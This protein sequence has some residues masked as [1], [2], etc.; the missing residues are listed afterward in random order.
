M[1][2]DVSVRWLSTA[3]APL[4]MVKLAAR[5][6]HIGQVAHDVV[7]LSLNLPDGVP[8]AFHAGQFAKLRFGKLPVR[9]YSMAS[10]PGE[11]RLEFHIRV[12]PDGVVSQHVVKQLKVG[13]K[14]EVR[15]PFGDAY[16]DH[17]E[18]AK[19]G[20]LLLLAG[21]TGL[22]PILSVLDAA[23]S[24]GMP[25]KQ[26]HVYHGVRTEDDLYAGSRLQTRMRERG[27]RFVPVF[28]SG[29]PTRARQGLLHEAVGQDFA[30]C[31][32]PASTWPARHRWWTR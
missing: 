20:P 24:D 21:G 26:I 5:V 13:D 12:L 27:F 19:Q 25:P 4:P 6:D 7:V 15:G 30:I 9:S 2:S 3:A 23:L 18:D 31:R 29:R 28:S 14:V 22:A 17:P 8:F 11:G 1:V 16:W 10:Q 32:R